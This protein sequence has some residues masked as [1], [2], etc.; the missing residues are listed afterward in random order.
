MPSADNH[1]EE[2]ISTAKL[3]TQKTDSQT[4]ERIECFLS[5]GGPAVIACSLNDAELRFKGF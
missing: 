2:I 5:Y 4:F 1:S 3:G